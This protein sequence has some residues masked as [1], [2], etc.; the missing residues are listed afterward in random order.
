MID[1]LNLEC[2][3]EKI[4]PS[5]GK[6]DVKKSRNAVDEAINTTRQQIVDSFGDKKVFK[7]KLKQHA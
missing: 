7:A 4:Q 6:K 5:Y 3:A 1:S 2:Y